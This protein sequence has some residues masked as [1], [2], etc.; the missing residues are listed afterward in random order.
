MNRLIKFSTLK[1]AFLK[2]ERGSLSVEA[3]IS[4]TCLLVLMFVMS[5]LLRTVYIYESVDHCIYNASKHIS[6]NE[7][8]VFLAQSNGAGEVLSRPIIVKAF[9]KGELDKNHIA[10]N[11]ER[12][13]LKRL[14]VH[15]L[16]DFDTE[17]G[18]GSYIVSYA[19]QLPGKLP[20]VPMT[21][22]LRIKSI[23]QSAKISEEV[24]GDID[25]FMVYTTSHG[26][27]NRIYH[28]HS[29]CWSLKRSWENPESVQVVRMDDLEGYRQCKICVKEE[30]GLE[31]AHSSE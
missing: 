17:A 18:A 4:A 6:V 19:L 25:D 23:W 14:E 27:K 12:E 30:L 2:S 10:A 26:R 29:D 21:H 9:V 31:E 8:Y 28:T 3:I 1:S 11:W 7:G 16:P 13:A 5:A 22:Q 20:E 24:E 15:E